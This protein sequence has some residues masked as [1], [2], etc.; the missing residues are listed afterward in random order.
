MDLETK[1]AQQFKDLYVKKQQQP[2]TDREA[3]EHFTHLVELVRRVYTPIPRS[4]AKKL[5]WLLSEHTR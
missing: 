3:M 1:Y 2:I 5:K 4:H